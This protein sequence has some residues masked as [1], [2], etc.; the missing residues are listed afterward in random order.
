MSRTGRMIASNDRCASEIEITECVERL[1]TC[2][3][4]VK[5]QTFR[6]FD[7]V[8]IENDRIIHRSSACE[9]SGEKCVVILAESECTC[10]GNSF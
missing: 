4:I 7:A 2:K 10:C 9:P 3:F 8:V 6:I 1:V 5:T